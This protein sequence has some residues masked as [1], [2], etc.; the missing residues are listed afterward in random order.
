MCVCVCT[1]SKLPFC[2]S[3]AESRALFIRLLVFPNGVFFVYSEQ[4]ARAGG[5]F[6]ARVA[7]YTHTR[8]GRVKRVKRAAKKKNVVIVSTYV[9]VWTVIHVRAW[10]Q[11]PSGGSRWRAKRLFRRKNKNPLEE[12]TST[13][14]VLQSPENAFIA[15][16]WYHIRM[17]WRRPYYGSFDSRSSGRSL[18][19][20]PRASNVIT[21]RGGGGNYTGR[22]YRRLTEDGLT[23]ISKNR[24]VKFTFRIKKKKRDF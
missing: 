6:C 3:E 20:G 13:W 19:S 14:R 18:S 16:E 8:A 5:V 10:P 22:C 12:I 1:Y 21:A 9:Y 23:A 7:L 15:H 11:E 24:Y 4:Q 17:R 2:T